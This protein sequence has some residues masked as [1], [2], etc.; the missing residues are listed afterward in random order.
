M[1]RSM[2]STMRA[3]LAVAVATTVLVA[4]PIPAG[5]SG[6]T[7]LPRGGAFAQGRAAPAAGP[8]WLGDDPNDFPIGVW[9]Q[10]PANA[11][12]YQDI[13]IHL[14]IGL[15]QGPTEDQLGA[16]RAVTMP[17]IADQNEVGLAHRD[18]PI[19][20]GWLQQDEPDNAQSDGAGGYGPC[21]G[22]AV[23]IA[24]YQAM[25]ANDPSRPVLLNLGQ[26]VAWDTDRP[27]VG[28][29][30]ACADQWEQYP[31]Y[32]KGADIVSFD[33]YPVTS[34]YDHLRGELWRVALG[35]DRLRQWTNGRK[36][37]WNVIET[38][39]IDSTAMPT[40]HQ[41]RAEVWMSLVHGSTG[42][43]YFAHEWQ[44]RFREAGLLYYPEMR[45]AVGELNRQ[46]H[47][48][49][50]VL[51]RPSLAGAVA[52]AST[53]PAVPVDL[54]VKRS[55]AWTYVFAVAMR[56]AP[57]TATFTFAGP[58]PH[59]AVEVIGEDRT[60]PLAGHSFTDAF[61]GYDVHLYRVPTAGPLDLPWLSR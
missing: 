34:P 47:D 20:A 35:V 8:A 27:Y 46:I 55:G 10:D 24:C 42:I 45:A 49:A 4:W 37:V 31:E 5:V 25:H 59:G 30:S 58:V 19:L 1:R 41:V 12:A 33:I 16:L 18:D 2:K 14:F 9:L 48:L 36:P 51:H 60:L 17:V 29:G 6:P 54:M 28:R 39:H 23:V 61:A 38:T 11:K 52:V 26:G 40:P 53:D 32:V 50:P 21:V 15:W 43:F 22:P 56:D 44:P 13:G 57:T 7:R 3:A